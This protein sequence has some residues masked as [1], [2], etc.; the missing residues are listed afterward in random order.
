MFIIGKVILFLSY[1]R[2]NPLKRS[3]FL[4]LFLVVFGPFLMPL[5]SGWLTLVMYIVFLTGVLII[6]VYCASLGGDFYKGLRKFFLS[7]SLIL[8]F[9]PYAHEGLSRVSYDILFNLN[10]L[11]YVYLIKIFTVPL[12]LLVSFLL[13]DRRALRKV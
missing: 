4:I 10:F 3:L 9:L 11:T 7:F 5:I 2:N 12:I 13:N 1:L 8:F 6:M